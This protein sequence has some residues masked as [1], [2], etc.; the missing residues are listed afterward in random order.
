MRKE[1]ED[2]T[3]E[4]GCKTAIHALDDPGGKTFRSNLLRHASTPERHMI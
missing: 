4:C 1:P 3:E 2:Q